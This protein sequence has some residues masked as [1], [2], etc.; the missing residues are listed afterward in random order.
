MTIIRPKAERLSRKPRKQKPKMS[1]VGLRQKRKP[2]RPRNQCFHLKVKM[3]RV[4]L[5][6]ECRPVKGGSIQRRKP[7]MSSQL[8]CLR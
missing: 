2:Q 1:K 7:L 6:I 5:N 4:N 8:P 3:T